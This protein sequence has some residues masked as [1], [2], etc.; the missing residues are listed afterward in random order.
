[1]CFP[2]ILCGCGRGARGI[3]VSSI[4]VHWVH[5]ASYYVGTRVSGKLTR[6]ARNFRAVEVVCPLFCVGGKDRPDRTEEIEDAGLQ[7]CEAS[8]PHFSV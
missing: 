3:W 2:H 4:W 5:V 1:M 7:G 8:S 6:G